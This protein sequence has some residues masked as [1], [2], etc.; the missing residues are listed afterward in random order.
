MKSLLLVAMGVA[1][2]TVG[3]QSTDGMMEESPETM[4]S[5]SMA[6]SESD[7][8]EA[9]EY[10]VT[11]EVL[12]E[13]PTP[14]APVAWA[15]HEGGNPFLQGDMGEKLPG[16]EALAED[17]DPGPVSDALGSL[18]DVIDHGV[19]AVPRNGS[20][21][22]PATPGTAYSFTVEVP[23]GAHL[24][25]ATMYVQSNDL[26]FSP[27][28]EGLS[29]TGEM[30]LRGDVTPEIKLFD[31]GTEVNEEPGMGAHQPPRQ[32]APNSGRSESK[33]IAEVGGMG[34]LEDYGEVHRILRV[35][36]DHGSM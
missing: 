12:P 8:M 32:S 4:D 28:E 21:P 9:E 33:P 36:L 10:L 16:L 17:G 19:A 23:R 7:S 3:C 15:V 34:G 27:G 1:L 6:M 31:A 13:S 5:E 14:L 30:A 29:L 22:G 11:I 20:A 2:L 24:S 25:F 35:T 26:F 18:M